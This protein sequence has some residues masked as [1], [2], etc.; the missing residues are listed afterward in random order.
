ML[1]CSL[2][3][4]LDAEWMKMIDF[5]RE[6]SGKENCECD[7]TMDVSR[8]WFIGGMA[9]TGAARVLRAESGVFW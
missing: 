4:M 9:A 8:R 7:V 1:R 2:F 6:N 3:A 5:L